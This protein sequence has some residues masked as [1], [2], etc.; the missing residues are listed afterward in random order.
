MFNKVSFISAMAGLVLL[1]VGFGISMVIPGIA[2]A[3][4]AKVEVCHVPPED[5]DNF[6]TI[7][8][9]SNALTPHLAHA[10][11]SGACNGLCAAICDD[12]DACT[13]DDTADCEQTGCPATPE[14]VNCDDSDMCT[15]DSCDSVLGCAN[16]PVT[17]EAPDACHIAACDPLQ[18]G[19]CVNT[20]ISCPEGFTCDDV[21]G[22]IEDVPDPCPC[23]TLTDL[24]DEGDILVCGNNVITEGAANFFVNLN[25][26][27]SGT[28]GCTEDSMVPVR[29]CGFLTGF[30]SDT[31][32][33]ANSFAL[34][35]T[36]EEDASCRALLLT[37]C[38]SAAASA[39]A[40]TS[41]P[42]I[43]SPMIINQ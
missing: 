24:Q 22:C 37:N 21:E 11:L 7:K 31:G 17:C 15:V 19:A 10:D 42:S 12:G 25:F 40:A 13:I 41:A 8:I 26:Y 23:F 34:E 27:C 20:P 29:G 30:D 2:V 4:G 39:S 3:G 16:V 32:M 6:H 43:P 35:V 14:P 36:A 9:S 1:C 33:Y 28:E 5:P 38:P 18:G